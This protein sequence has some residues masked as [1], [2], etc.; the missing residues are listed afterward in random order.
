MS[1]LQIEF[2]LGLAAAHD[3]R[4]GP[5][6]FARIGHRRQSE[7]VGKRGHGRIDKIGSTNNCNAIAGAVVTNAHRF[8][9]EAA[10]VTRAERLASVDDDAI[11]WLA[12][13]LRGIAFGLSEL[14]GRLGLREPR[15]FFVHAGA[16]WLMCDRDRLDHVVQSEDRANRAGQRLR[17]DRIRGVRIGAAVAEA[18]DPHI[19]RMLCLCDITFET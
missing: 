14:N 19:E 6:Y 4:I 16:F 3:T 2:G 18:C 9:I 13:A 10:H 12:E 17:H 7:L 8:V 15:G 1:P 5:V 11:N